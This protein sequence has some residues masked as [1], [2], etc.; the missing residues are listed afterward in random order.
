MAPERS[1]LVLVTNMKS[2]TGFRLVSKL[3]TLNDR[4]WRNDC[5]HAL[6]LW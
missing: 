2:H 5:Q 3:V 4:E 1:K 6:Y